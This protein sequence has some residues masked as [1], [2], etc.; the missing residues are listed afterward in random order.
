[1]GDEQP[2]QTE[3]GAEVGLSEETT[4]VAI[5]PSHKHPW[6]TTGVYIRRSIKLFESA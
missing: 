3:W 6:V 4:Y 1:M 2:Q 5:Y